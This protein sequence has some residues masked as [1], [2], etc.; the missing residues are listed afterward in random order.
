MPQADGSLLF[1]SK[2]DLAG[3]QV[4]V[5]LVSDAIQGIGAKLKDLAT[6]VLT[7]GMTFESSM[8][9]VAALSGAT[10]AELESLT[11]TAKE[12][13]AA[14]QF[15]AAESAQ[16]FKYMAL[17]GWDATQMTEAL[18]GVLNLAASSGMELA[19]ASDIVTDYL[20]AFGMEASEATYLADLL[21]YAQ[22]NSNTTV[23]QLSG[24]YKN[25]AANL[26]SA[27]QTV[28]T[29]TALLAMMAN[30]GFKG[31]EA[32][33]AL[34][35]VMRDLSNN[36][37]LVDDTFVKGNEELKGQEGYIENLSDLYGQ[38]VV[39]IGNT[40]VAVSDANGNYRQ[41]TD[42]LEDFEQATNGMTEAEQ[43]SA[44]QNA[45]TA[46]SIKGV[47]M[48]LN[49]GSQSAQEF[50]AELE[51]SA[52]TAADAAATM[53]DNI[54]GDLAN[55]SS[56]FEGLQLNVFEEM[57]EPIR[58]VLQ[59]LAKT[60]QD[61]KT[62]KAASDLGKV[63]ADMAKTL[64]NKLPD[65]IDAVSKVVKFLWD[66]KGLIAG[67]TT[68]IA[69]AKGLSTISTVLKTITTLL[70]SSSPL[71]WVSLGV[72]AIA[73]LIAYTGT[74]KTELEKVYEEHAKIPDEV[75]KAIDK[76][77]E[78]EEEWENVKKETA[79]SGLQIESEHTRISDLKDSMLALL[80]ADGTI[81]TGYEEKVTNILDELNTYSG[82]AWTVS[83]NVIMANDEIIGS[84]EGISAAIDQVIEKQYAQNYLELF[85]EE[86]KQAASLRTELLSSAEEIKEEIDSTEQ[87]I[88][89]AK[90][91]MKEL[92]QEN[93]T[94]TIS[95]ADGTTETFK[96]TFDQWPEDAKREYE[97]WATVVD[98]CNNKLNG[99]DGLISKYKSSIKD[100]Q[101]NTNVQDLYKESLAAFEN[102]DYDAV[103]S[104][105]ENRNHAI[106][107]AANATKEELELQLDEAQLYY[108]TL[109]RMA[110]ENPGSVTE[111]ELRASK[112]SL[113]QA[114]VEYVK[115][116]GDG[117]KVTGESYA[118][119][120][121]NTDVSLSDTIRYLKDFITGEMDMTETA[122]SIGGNTGEVL[123][124]EM[125]DEVE[126]NLWSPV[127]AMNNLMSEIENTSDP[128][129][130]GRSLGADLMSGLEWGI[131]GNIWS[132][133]VAMGNAINAV[134][135]SG[136]KAADSHSPS[137]KTIALGEDIDKGLEI[138]IANRIPNISNI[139]DTAVSS[140]LSIMHAQ[141]A[142]SIAP[143]N[144]VLQQAYSVPQ[145]DSTPAA[146]PS[147]NNTTPNIDLHAT[148]MLDNGQFELAVIDAVTRAN[149]ASGGW[150][151]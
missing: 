85:G 110:E 139:A 27:G 54:E 67:I 52:G 33:T 77:K 127:A 73:G 117:G 48:M 112:D 83:G 36:M 149:A 106:L 89:D 121:R 80:N 12:Y 131:N 86:A 72:S 4:G 26:H 100:L 87:E 141:G 7:T 41:L 28:E 24:A 40:A 55:L 50:A 20:S 118:D 142:S 144:P 138:G 116:A 6:S 151:V 65:A 37:Y 147:S 88:E 42:V 47:N 9:E 43:N 64:A 51:D 74:L 53:Q 3:F 94:Y 21:S 32:G 29:T 56:A 45:L 150:S 93:S 25:C 113:N 105:Y 31:E 107:T 30:Q 129:E 38:Y 58:D 19:E 124:V 15:T 57:K 133:V 114:I 70:S 126:R 69:V 111:E 128:F 92:E 49:A 90:S 130:L 137:K 96:A 39:D 71:G 75:Q 103:I 134:N 34:S 14:T 8:S 5:D 102:G 135:E 78:Y 140:A 115:A 46:D 82:M 119:A 136:R 17:A 95:Y 81:K 76:T 98:A 10:S 1:D 91:R 145:Q 11:E 35:A 101:E 125:A 13:G 68:A 22:A 59:T 2:L 79:N 146:T 16:A 60:L 109:K 132:P 148:L 104:N 97:E 84:Y 23:E 108:D 99:E 122:K 61:S 143:Y 44:L 123:C 66:N 62:Q 63:L 18:P 120:L